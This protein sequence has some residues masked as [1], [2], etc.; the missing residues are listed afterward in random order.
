MWLTEEPARCGG[1]TAGLTPASAEEAMARL[2][3]PCE[4]WTCQDSTGNLALVTHP[5]TPL[6]LRPSFV[7]S[8]GGE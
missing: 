3:G 4:D 5:F 1:P 6:G 8:E 2:W 7:K